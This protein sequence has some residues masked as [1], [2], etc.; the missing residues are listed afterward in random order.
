MLYVFIIGF[1]ASLLDIRLARLKTKIVLLNQVQYTGG[2]EGGERRG[3]GRIS[4]LV[5]FPSVMDQRH[6]LSQSSSDGDI[7]ARTDSK[8]W[9]RKN[10]AAQIFELSLRQNNLH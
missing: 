7:G 10:E 3:R 6:N 8:G 1:S 2:V 4:Y 5:L 9:E